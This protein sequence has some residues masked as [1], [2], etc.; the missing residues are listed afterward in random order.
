MA[1]YGLVQ[2]GSLRFQAQSRA[3]ML[4][5]QFLSTAEWN[6]NIASSYKELYDLLVTSYGDDYYV[7][8]PY[9][10]M[11]SS[12]NQLYPLPNGTTTLDLITNIVAVP[13]YKLIG[14]DLMI[15]SSPDSWITLRKYE[16]TERNKYYLANQYALYGIITLRYRIIGPNIWF[17][18][19]PVPTQQIQL[20]YVPEPTNLQ[21]NLTCG[22]TIGSAVVTTSDTS[23]LSVGMSVGDLATPQGVVPV[24]PSGT[25]I[26]S[27]VANISF[28]MSAVATATVPIKIIAAWSDATT[29]DGISGWEEFVVID[30]A[31][32]ARIKEES[33]VQEL[34]AQ[35]AAMRIRII[36]TAA[37]RDASI[38]SRVTDTQS[39]DI[40]WPGGLGGGDGGIW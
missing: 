39:I 31:L 22:T 9:R 40:G 38:P 10:F 30:A 18:P 20:W 11:T 37:N 2:L 5:S 28:T 34:M 12:A 32:K 25:T 8:P 23:Q 35:K 33:P 13:F 24:V 3:D 21:A 17:T 27:I 1:N 6:T 26:L 14:V 29:L 36:D 15:T 4:N 16:F 7:A 19:V